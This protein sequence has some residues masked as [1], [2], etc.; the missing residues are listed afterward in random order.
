MRVYYENLPQQEGCRERERQMR[1]K[2]IEMLAEFFRQNPRAALGF[3]GGVDSAWLLYAGIKAGAEIQPYY[4]R[5]AFQPD[6][7]LRDAKRLCGELGTALNIVELDIFQVEEAV[8]N[9]HNRCY[10]CKKALFGALKEQA[11]RDGFSILLDGTNASDDA[12]DRPG[13]QAARELSV[14]SPLRE[15]G[16]TKAEVREMSRQAGLFTWNKPAY[17]CLATRI[18]AGEMITDE[19][20]C[21][22]EAGEN[23]LFGMGFSDFRIR[24]FHGAAR[25][26]L[27][28]G[29]MG[30]ALEKRKEITG[31]LEAVG[32]DGILLD[33]KER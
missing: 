12:D 29:Q 30:T 2:K 8:K 32:F 19:K 11:V 24:L 28:A 20:L 4:I 27:P 7:E 33:L 31:K 10:Y 15:C 5:T 21:R 26:Q 25:I 1:E 9:P 3:S 23:E 13:M 22:I 14:R 16:I 17:A 18:P 6:F